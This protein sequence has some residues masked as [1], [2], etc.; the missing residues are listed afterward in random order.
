MENNS[1]QSYLTFG[2]Y[3]SS[4]LNEATSE[5]FKHCV[6]DFT[7]DSH[8]E[9]ELNCL[10]SCFGKYLLSYANMGDLLEI[11]NIPK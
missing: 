1:A 7:K 4:Y 3:L 8:S 6:K 11:K 10:N 2:D 9:N 5:C